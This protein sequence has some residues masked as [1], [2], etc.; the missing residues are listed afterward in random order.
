MSSF[1]PSKFTDPDWLNT[2]S[3]E[4]LIALLSPWRGH[5]AE[6]GVGLPS[7]HTTSL[8]RHALARALLAADNRTPPAMIDALY[9]IH[10]TSAVED[11]DDLRARVRGRGVAIVDDPL[12]TSADYVIDV[13]L[14][15]PELVEERHA[16]KMAFREKS[17]VYFTGLGGVAR[18]FPVVDDAAR[19]QIERALDAW[20]SDHGRG[21]A[22][23]LHIIRQSPTVYLLVRHGE[24]MR[25]EASHADD[26]HVESA[27]YRPQ[28]HDVLIY[29]EAHDQI[30]VHAGTKGEQRLYLTEL[31]R[32]LF[33]NAG[34]F[35]I[36]DK[37]SLKPLTE[38]GVMALNCADVPG[39]QE[40]RL[41]SHRQVF[42]GMFKKN[43]VHRAVDIFGELGLRGRDRLEYLPASATFQVLFAGSRKPR[44]VV[45]TPPAIASYERNEDS[46][47][48]ER[49]LRARGFLANEQYVETED[50]A[51]PAA[52]LESAG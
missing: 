38:V 47:L 48:I 22:S 19:Q 28:K 5:L 46:E 20:F 44:R 29:D 41:I 36:A 9:F 11:A 15:C 2:L 27:F 12:A 45:I 3:N 50:D 34:Y 52:L 24:P 13:W 26:G 35:P 30:G 21:R 39:L 25:R 32:V 6:R 10:E 18:K 1:N 23:R 40:I 33:G 17:F 49:W 7:S 14:V 8:D 4:R 16:E 43:E 31:G 37:Y 51:A 42:G